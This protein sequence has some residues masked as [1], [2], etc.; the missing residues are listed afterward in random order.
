MKRVVITGIGAVTAFGKTWQEIKTAFQRKQNAVQAKADWAERYP[1][2]EARLGAE[3][4]GYQPPSHWNRKQLRSLGRVSQF[5][6]EAAERALANADLLDENGDILAYLKDGR[7]GVACGSSTGSTND[8]KDAAELLMTGKSDGFNANTYV[9]MMP[10]TT[11]ANIGIFFGLTGRI[12]PTSSACSSGSQGIGYAYESIKYGLIPM[13]LAGGAE[14]FCPSEVYVFD[15]LYAASR[16]VNNPSKTPRPYDNDRDGL[17]IGEGAGI[18]VLEELEHALARG[19]NIIA[20]VV[21]YGA[22]SDGAHVTR[23]QKDT[24]QRCMELALKDAHLS[25]Q[26]IG[27]VNGHG[28]ATE[29]GDIAE[30]LATE[31]VFGKVPLSSQKSYLGHTLGACGALESWFSIEMMRD[32]WFA[33]T[34]NLDNIDERCGKLDYIQGDGRHIETDYVMN[35]NFAFGGVNT[36][37]IF[38]RWQA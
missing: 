1:E 11:T 30:T 7:M 28:T 10:H 12:I 26:K 16:N 21:G 20:E 37:L 5:A 35:N 38:K 2:L 15:S 32:G 8:I 33:P 36:S 19:A 34:I 24:M 14:E 13:M 25:A 9:R 23:P 18:F 31:A 29:Q 22:N 4:H 3:I 17:V 27:Y 6:V